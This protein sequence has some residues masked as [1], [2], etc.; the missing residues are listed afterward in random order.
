MR[1]LPSNIAGKLGAA[2]ELFAEQGLDQTKMEDVAH[3]TGVGKTTLYYYF[4]SKEELLAHLLA[5][6][7]RA[8]ADAVE[9][10]LDGPGSAAHRLEGVIEAQVRVMNDHPAVCRALLSELGRAGRIPEIADAIAA[11][12]YQ[13]VARLL[14]EGAAD[15][16]LRTVEDDADALM[17]VFGAVTITGLHYLVRGEPIPA[18]TVTRTAS[19]LLDGL[20]R[21][22]R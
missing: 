1:T 11:A 3:V 9:V 18:V 2:A 13:P 16:S 15:G 6:A 5:D 7:L 22:D 21:N 20:G 17:A 10:A 14:A 12:Y 19:L 8:I 4:A